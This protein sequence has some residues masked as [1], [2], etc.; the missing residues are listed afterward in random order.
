ML[1]K[2]QYLDLE[3]VMQ[4]KRIE[5]EKANE[6]KVLSQ[7]KDCFNSNIFWNSIASNGK[8]HYEI[9]TK[10]SCLIV[11]E[12]DNVERMR[13]LCEGS[14]VG[15]TTDFKTEGDSSKYPKIHESN[16]INEVGPNSLSYTAEKAIIKACRNPY[17]RLDCFES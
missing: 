11:V 12:Y 7:S 13:I 6:F 5:K 1:G 16:T 9:L 4:S 15:K 3:T 14:V 2:E 8:T 17:V 10:N